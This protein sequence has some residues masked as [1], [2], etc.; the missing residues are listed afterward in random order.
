M[1]LQL[2]GTGS[3]GSNYFNACTLVNESLLIDMPNGILKNMKR[4][5]L[6]I[7]S[8]KHVFITHLHGDHFMDIPFY[9]LYKFMNKY[10]F[11]TIIY[12][13]EGLCD[14]VKTIYEVAFPGD[15]E[16]I[17]DKVNV[18]FIEYTENDEFELDV[19]GSIS[20]KLKP[21]LVD[22]G[23]L[24]PAYGCI[25][26]DGE[27]VAGFSGD[28]IY[29]ENIEKILDKSNIVIFD[30]SLPY[31]GNPS[32]MGLN[33]IERL[34]NEHIDKKIVCTHMGDGARDRALNMYLKNM[35]VPE[36]GKIIEI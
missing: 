24:K 3:I 7:A 19:P 34:C 9:M 30:A 31:D 22:H 25:V 36:D 8:I 12:G 2:L 28:S 29:T 11:E 33:D 17:I 13:P 1:K 26:N 15:Y 23:D 27:K 32:H 14:K 4:F 21:I 5:G 6:D 20:M 18:R 16:R 10:S 35:I